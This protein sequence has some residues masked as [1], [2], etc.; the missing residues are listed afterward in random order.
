VTVAQGAS[1]QTLH[2]GDWLTLDTR[3]GANSG[4]FDPATYQ[5]WR[6]DWLEADKM[7]LSYVVAKLNHYSSTP[8]VIADAALNGAA[9]SG[10]FQL[11]NTDATLRLIA[12]ALDIRQQNRDHRVYLTTRHS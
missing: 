2:K 4:H 1:I 10:R 3:L 8:I 11:S 12:A 9:L 5:N 7:P 6:T